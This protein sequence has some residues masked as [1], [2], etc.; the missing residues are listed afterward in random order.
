MPIERIGG[1]LV[2]FATTQP[3]DEMGRLNGNVGKYA[4]Q[5]QKIGAF[6]TELDLV[7]AD[8]SVRQE[9]LCV[10]PNMHG[11]GRRILDLVERGNHVT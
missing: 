9:L 4:V 11:L 1:G 8:C 3:L 10:R 2:V 6:E 5:H 7:F